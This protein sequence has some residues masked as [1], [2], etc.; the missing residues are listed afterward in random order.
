MLYV[1]CLSSL[2]QSMVFMVQSPTKLEPMQRIRPKGTAQV[3]APR[4]HRPARFQML[5]LM[6]RA[7]ELFVQGAVYA[8]DEKNKAK[9]HPARAAPPGTSRVKHPPPGGHVGNASVRTLSVMML[10]VG[11][12]ENVTVQSAL[13]AGRVS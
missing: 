8:S 2:E 7:Q 3:V 6:R 1:K 9:V 5:W 4:H 12:P 10:F 13:L 11:L